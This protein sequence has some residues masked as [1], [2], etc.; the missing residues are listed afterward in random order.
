MVILLWVL[1]RNPHSD[2]HIGCNC[3]HCCQEQE[4]IRVPCQ[5]LV[6]FVFL[7]MAFLIG[8]ELNL[9]VVFISIA[10]VM[11]DVEY[12]KGC[13]LAIT[14]N[15]V[16]SFLLGFLFSYSLDFEFFVY[17]GYLSSVRCAPTKDYLTF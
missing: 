11:R 7:M 8:V 6:I 4:G 16:S 10:L 3:M 17:S 14:I 12:F 2:S 15:V 1:L 9:K 13:I 5:C